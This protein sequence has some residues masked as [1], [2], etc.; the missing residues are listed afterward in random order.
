MMMVAM[1]ILCILHRDRPF[2]IYLHAVLESGHALGIKG[3][4]M[5]FAE[6]RDL[7]LVDFCVSK[8]IWAGFVNAKDL[9]IDIV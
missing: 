1:T 7:D 2:P 3:W 9:L 4:S 6:G 8:H 5:N